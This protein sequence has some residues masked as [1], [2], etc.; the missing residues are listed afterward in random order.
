MECFVRW[1]KETFAF[2]SSRGAIYGFLLLLVGVLPAQSFS[3]PLADGRVKFLGGGTNSNVW[4]NFYLY[5]N[6]VTPGNDGKWESVEGVRGQY[7]WAGLDKIYDYATSNS[8]LFKDHCLVWGNQ[9]PSWIS[10]LDTASQRAAVRKWIDTVGHRYPSMSFI[11]VVNEPFHAPPVYMKALGDS[12]STGWDWVITAFQWSRESCAHGVKL[13]LNEY[14]ILQDNTQTT[15]YINLINLLKS[16]GL[17]D[18]IGIQGHYF[19]FRSHVGA[20]SNVYVYNTSTIRGNLDRLAAVGLPIYI[21]EFDIDEPDDATQLAQYQIYFPIFWLHPGVKGM[22]FWGYIQNDVWSSYPNT[23][24]IRLNGTERPALQWIR[25][26][27]TTGPIPD[28]PVLVSP[29]SV[30]NAARKPILVWRSSAYA[31]SYRLRVATDNGFAAIVCDTTLADTTVT[32]STPL[33]SNTTYFWQ[34][35]ASSPAG[36][37]QYS[38]TAFFVTGLADAVDDKRGGIPKWFGL[39]QNYPN[40]FNPSTTIQYD[41][42]VTS[43][44]T[45]T[46]HDLLGRVVTTLV[47]QVQPADRHSVQWNA[48]AISSGVYFYHLNVRSGDGSKTF[49]SVKKLLLMK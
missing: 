31:K 41:L 48:S 25:T 49:S 9:Q 17:I 34:V 42:P 47:D 19:E 11:D 1:M 38:T 33:G 45:L 8:I 21:S 12:G 10:S 35:N 13:I 44:V 4:Q 27:I 43:H 26:F 37:S 2:G 36:T 23:Y 28:V 40:P 5:W 29:R 15:N 46:I 24:L 3:Q 6:Q 32:F 7:N 30:E 39:S 18:G 22:T 14:N 20:T 16:R